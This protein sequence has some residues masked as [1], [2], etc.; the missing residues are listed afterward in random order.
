MSL[1]FNMLDLT[2][3][4]RHIHN[5]ASFPLWSSLFILSG[6]ISLLFP[7]SI[8]AHSSVLAWRIPRMGEPGGLPSM[9]SHRVGHDWSNLA[10]AAAYWMSSDLGGSS[11][12]VISFCLFI[13]FMRFLR[14]EYWSGLPFPPPGDHVLSE[15]S[16]RTYSSWSW[17]ALQGITHSF[18]ELYKPLCNDKAVIYEEECEGWVLL[19]KGKKERKW[20]KKQLPLRV[21]PLKNFFQWYRLLLPLK[22]CLLVYKFINHLKGALFK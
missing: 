21:A 18:T 1:L 12:S 6:A 4:T 22:H 2:F 14:Q 19:F 15:L 17:V 16:T 11:S 8:L 3:T 13:L 5:W 20:K 7:R 10:A 9:G